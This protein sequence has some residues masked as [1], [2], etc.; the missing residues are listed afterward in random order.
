MLIVWDEIKRQSNLAKHGLDFAALDLDFFAASFVAQSSQGRFV[1]VGALGEAMITVVF[2]PLGREAI[3][4]IS[5]RPSSRKERAF[6]D[7]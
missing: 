6:H 2:S 1:A 3:S 5:M 4:I 7:T